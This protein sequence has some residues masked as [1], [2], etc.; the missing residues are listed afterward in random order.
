MFLEQARE[1][2]LETGDITLLAPRRPMAAKY[3]EGS[4]PLILKVP[5][6]ELEARVGKTQQFIAVS[7]KPTEPAQALEL[8]L[9][10][11]A[12]AAATEPGGR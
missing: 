5:R 10:G 7:I 12:A 4:M 11:R 9:V 2:L 8:G 6:R 1:V 3:I